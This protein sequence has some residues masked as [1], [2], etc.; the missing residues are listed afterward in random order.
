MR[1]VRPAIAADPALFGRRRVVEAAGEQALL[2]SEDVRLFLTTFAAGFAF[3]AL[4]IA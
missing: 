2:S 1:C 4:F 3:V